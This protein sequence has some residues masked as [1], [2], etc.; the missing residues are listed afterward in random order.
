[1]EWRGRTTVELAKLFYIAC[2][3]TARSRVSLL[4]G[5]SKELAAVF[6]QIGFRNM[7]KEAP[8]TVLLPR[9]LKDEAQR[10]LQSVGIMNA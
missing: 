6:L 9:N 7:H 5:F 10:G 8:T 3:S 2:R 4:I 1:V